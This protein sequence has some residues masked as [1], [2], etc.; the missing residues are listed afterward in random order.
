MV[1]V[2]GGVVL[3]LPDQDPGPGVRLHRLL[4]ALLELL[5]AWVNILPKARGVE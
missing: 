3:R 2:P 5:E 4:A 1:E